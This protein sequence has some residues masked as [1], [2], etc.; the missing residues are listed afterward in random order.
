MEGINN[1]TPDGVQYEIFVDTLEKLRDKIDTG[2]KGVYDRI[3][4]INKSSSL[5][6]VRCFDRFNKLELQLAVDK[7]E[8][9][10]KGKVEDEKKDIWKYVIRSGVVMMMGYVAYGILKII[11]ANLHVFIK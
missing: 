11:E 4:D 2:F 6:S 5:R 8:E 9:E 1:M 10:V 3:D 7:K